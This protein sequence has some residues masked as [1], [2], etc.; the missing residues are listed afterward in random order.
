MSTRKNNTT[1][2]KN[3]KRIYPITLNATATEKAY[4]EHYAH[5]HGIKSISSAV[6]ELAYAPKRRE[7]HRSVMYTGLVEIS[8]QIDCLYDLIHRTGSDYIAKSD[9]LPIIDNTKKGCDILWK[10]I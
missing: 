8:H 5:T 6:S 10:K 1:T 4:Y 2:S 7:R 3:E 9:I